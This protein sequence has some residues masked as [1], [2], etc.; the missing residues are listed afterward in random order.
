MLPLK[1]AQKMPWLIIRPEK[2]LVTSTPTWQ[3]VLLPILLIRDES[4]NTLD[5]DESLP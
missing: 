1:K 5:W 3:E 2:W 4:W